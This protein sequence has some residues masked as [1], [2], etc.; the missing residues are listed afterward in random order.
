MVD[1]HTAVVAIATTQRRWFSTY[2]DFLAKLMGNSFVIFS[3]KNYPQITCFG[4]VIPKIHR[5]LVLDTLYKRDKQT[6]T[7]KECTYRF[8]Y[9]S[10]G[11]ASSANVLVKCSRT[12]LFQIPMLSVIVHEHVLSSNNNNNRVTAFVPGQP[13]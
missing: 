12:L 2:T 1:Q 7:D 9:Q 4:K 8:K 6:V 3:A 13:G 11:N 10:A 5:D